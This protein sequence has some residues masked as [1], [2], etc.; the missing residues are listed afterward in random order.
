MTWANFIRGILFPELPATAYGKQVELRKLH[1]KIGELGG[2]IFYSDSVGTNID[3]PEH[4][5]S[6]TREGALK[7]EGVF[8]VSYFLAKKT[9]YLKDSTG[10]YDVNMA[11]KGFPRK[12]ML[13][14]DIWKRAL[15]GE[16]VHIEDD[17]WKKEDFR[18]VR[19]IPLTKSFKMN[20]D[21]RI[22]REDG[23]SSHFVHKDNVEERL[24]HSLKGTELELLAQ[25][26]KARVLVL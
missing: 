13:G 20:L 10:K 23:T 12:K 16:S 11:S 1:S 8:D 21:G 25:G 17:Y 2:K 6:K 3:L 9:Y 7:F 4:M 14:E 26:K 5:I 18:K 19:I 22:Y 15:N 24:I